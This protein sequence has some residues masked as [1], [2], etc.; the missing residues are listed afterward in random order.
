MTMPMP[1]AFNSVIRAFIE[2]LDKELP[3]TDPLNVPGEH[4]R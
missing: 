1:G 4:L 2:L 3:D